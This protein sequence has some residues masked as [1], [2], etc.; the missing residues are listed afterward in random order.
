MFPKKSFR[1]QPQLKE[2]G[3]KINDKIKAWKVL[4]I[5]HNG[6]N[7]GVLG[8]KEAIQKS[9]DVGLDL[10]EIA[11]EANPPVVRRGS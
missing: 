7:L 6:N 9:R 1:E 2:N 3:L 8:N 10:V 5:D 11:P 4:V